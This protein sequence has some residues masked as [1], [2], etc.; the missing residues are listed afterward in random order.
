[1]C[2][3]SEKVAQAGCWWL[4]PVILATQEGRDQE[5][6]GLK[7]ALA[8]SSGNPISKKPIAIKGLVE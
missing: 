3:H 5:N 1:M 4:V 8:N 7:P 2:Q 6:Q